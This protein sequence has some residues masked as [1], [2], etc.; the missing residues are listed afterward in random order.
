MVDISRCENTVKGSY[1]PARGWGGEQTAGWE[2]VKEV[3]SAVRPGAW[4]A[5][6]RRHS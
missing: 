1:T 3:R 4:R 6:Q 5:V 2:K